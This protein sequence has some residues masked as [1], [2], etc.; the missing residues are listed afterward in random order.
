MSKAM[1]IMNEVRTELVRIKNPKIN[2]KERFATI[3][4]L[5][6]KL[7][8]ITELKDAKRRLQRHNEKLEQCVAERTRKLQKANKDLKCHKEELQANNI[9]LRTLLR[10]VEQEK[11]LIEKKVVSNFEHAILPLLAEFQVL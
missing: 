9:A 4:D 10:V 5:F 11:E 1:E 3:D 8:D 2:N 6:A 7:A